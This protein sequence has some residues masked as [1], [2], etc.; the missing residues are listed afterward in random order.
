MR[1]LPSKDLR[2][3]IVPLL[4]AERTLCGNPGIWHRANWRRDIFN[5]F[6]AADCEIALPNWRKIEQEC[7]YRGIESEAPMWISPDREPNQTSERELDGSKS[8]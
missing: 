6:L 4:A 3:K 8:Q 1:E 7:Q 2:G 5:A